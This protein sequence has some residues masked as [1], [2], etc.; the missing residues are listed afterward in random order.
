[1]P[2]VMLAALVLGMAIFVPSKVQ[3]VRNASLGA[4]NEPGENT[5]GD[6][7]NGPAGTAVTTPGGAVAS[8][9]A[10]KAT[11]IPAGGNA[12]TG[13]ALQVP[14]DPYSPPCVSFSGSNGG[15]TWRGVTPTEIH[16]ATRR[17]SDASL[18]D[19]IAQIVGTEIADSPADVQRTTQVLVDYFNQH[20]QFYGRKIV[21][22]AYDGQGS[23]QTELLGN[24]RDK[25]EV[26]ATRVGKELK[27]FGDI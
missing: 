16:I 23:I 21:L 27:S 3:S 24:G 19:A 25:A 1:G 22:D 8:G 11:P 17:T 15:A 26:D 20:F 5:P 12:C 10:G 7:A 4:I 9:T 6:Q 2:F 13:R 18:D 14:N